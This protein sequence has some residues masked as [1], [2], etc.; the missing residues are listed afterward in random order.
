MYNKFTHQFDTKI[1]KLA[2]WLMDYGYCSDHCPIP[3]LYLKGYD[4]PSSTKRAE[5]TDRSHTLPPAKRCQRYRNGFEIVENIVQTP[6]IGDHDYDNFVDVNSLTLPY[7]HCESCHKKQNLITDLMIEVMEKD[8]IIECLKRENEQLKNNVTET[9]PFSIESIMNDDK[10]V[11]FYTGLQNYA[12]F[13]WIYNKVSEKAKRLI[14]YNGENSFAAKS[15]NKKHKK[16]GPKRKLDS[17]NELFLTFV[18]I[19][20]GLVEQDPGADLEYVKSV[21]RLT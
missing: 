3:T 13:E 6:H 8:K 9:K 21:K 17:K 1:Q 19:R 15:R 2:S 16:S 4:V 5:P 18:R 11:S 14:Y 12:M 10:A 7:N 20:L